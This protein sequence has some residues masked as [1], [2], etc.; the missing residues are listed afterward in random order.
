MRVA[1]KQD[2]GCSGVQ[3]TQ[4]HCTKQKVLARGVCEEAKFD[5]IIDEVV[6]DERM[7]YRA[8]ELNAR[9]I[10]SQR[11]ELTGVNCYQTSTTGSTATNFAIPGAM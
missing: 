8:A 11:Q 6:V 10:K 9:W 3:Y 2:N 5:V 4:V 7:G 1:R